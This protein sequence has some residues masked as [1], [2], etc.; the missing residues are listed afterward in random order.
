MPSG[1]EGIYNTNIFVSARYT[2]DDDDNTEY[3]NKQLSYNVH[4]TT[5]KQFRAE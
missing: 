1:L 3:G 5:N 4:N 2:Y